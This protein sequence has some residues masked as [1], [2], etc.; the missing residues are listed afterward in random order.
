VLHGNGHP[1]DIKV[2]ARTWKINRNLIF[3][4]QNS[5]VTLQV[6]VPVRKTFLSGV[7]RVRISS[8]LIPREREKKKLDL[9]CSQLILCQHIEFSLLFNFFWSDDQVGSV[10]HFHHVKTKIAAE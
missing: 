7:V 9:R 3:I 1:Q 6:F 10:N 2:F 4:G 5:G 8:L